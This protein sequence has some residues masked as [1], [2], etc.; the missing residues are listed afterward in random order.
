MD[1]K[2][3]MLF[4]TDNGGEENGPSI[5]LPPHSARSDD[6]ERLPPEGLHERDLLVEQHLRL[7]IRRVLLRLEEKKI[8]NLS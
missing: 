6:D 5:H 1:L 8:L 2:T 3:G 7:V 4:I